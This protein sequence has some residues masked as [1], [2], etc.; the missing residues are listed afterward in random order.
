MAKKKTSK[1][2][3]K[4]ASKQLKSKTTSKKSKATAASALSQYEP[5]QRTHKK[6]K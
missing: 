2:V 5:K 4:I 6:K 3:A 1:K